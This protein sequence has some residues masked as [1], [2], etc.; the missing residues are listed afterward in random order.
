VLLTRRWGRRP[1]IEGKV[2][3]TSGRASS[4]QE[5]VTACKDWHEE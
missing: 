3:I 4:Q 1:S 2:E 5:I